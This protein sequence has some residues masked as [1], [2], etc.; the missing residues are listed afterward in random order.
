MILTV[1]SIL[2]M[3]S[4]FFIP[5]GNG[6]NFKT[7]PIFRRSRVHKVPTKKT[8]TPQSGKFFGWHNER[9]SIRNPHF[10]LWGSTYYDENGCTTYDPLM[11]HECLLIGVYFYRLHPADTLKCLV[12]HRNG[13]ELELKTE[14]VDF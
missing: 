9:N 6:K 12:R 8:K 2:T 10:R 1:E 14:I 11:T 3:G 13:Q 4:S 5:R 7:P